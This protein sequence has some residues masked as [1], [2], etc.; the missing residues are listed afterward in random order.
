MN[1]V[2]L[3]LYRIRHHLG[4]AG[5]AGLAVGFSGLLIYLFAVLPVERQAQSGAE[6]LSRMRSQPGITSVV[7]PSRM[8]EAETMARFY[9]QFPP[10]HNL[11]EL[12]KKLH[13]LAQKHEVALDRA[14]FKFGS[15]EGERLL[16]YEITLPVKSS[17]P[18]LRSFIDEASRKLPT[19][20]LSEITLKREA[21]GDNLVQARLN[22]VLYLA[23]N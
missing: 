11:P 18:H 5:M 6:R 20:G 9:A 23:D 16:R 22:F 4:L 15:A 19:M 8:G 1:H 12:L 17:Y 2:V 10:M 3:H 21:V 7:E 13:A 14:D